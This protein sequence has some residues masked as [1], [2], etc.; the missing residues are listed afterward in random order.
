MHVQALAAGARVWKIASIDAG[1]SIANRLLVASGV[2]GAGARAISRALVSIK[3]PTR[4]EKTT[5]LRRDFFTTLPCRSKSVRWAGPEAAHTSTPDVPSRPIKWPVNLLILHRSGPQNGLHKFAKIF[6][7]ADFTTVYRSS[8][9]V[10]AIARE[11]PLIL[12]PL[13]GRFRSTP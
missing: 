6:A 8:Q 3:T 4:D 10:I 11:S 13:S 5:T 7:G 12:P 2:R 1:A 9:A